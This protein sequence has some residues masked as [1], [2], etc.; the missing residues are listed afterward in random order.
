MTMIHLNCPNCLNYFDRKIKDYNKSIKL[1]HN[2]LC[3]RECYFQYNNK[4]R[5]IAIN[6]TQC[7]KSIKRRKSA[8]K[9]INTFCSHSCKAVYYNSRSK[10]FTKVSKLEIWLQKKLQD[11]YPNID[12]TFNSKETINSEL[13]IYIPSLKLAFEL[14]GIFHYEPIFGQDKLD[15]TQNNDNRK[16]QACTEHSISL[17]VIDTSNQ[18][19]FKESTSKKFLDIIVNIINN[20]LANLQISTR[21]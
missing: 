20:H 1:G 16:F 13:D 4:I 17:C 8:V 7:N 3:S 18:I 19:Y 5:S 6:C 2:M 11:I 10:I 15:K 21:L 14:N 9:S 12:F